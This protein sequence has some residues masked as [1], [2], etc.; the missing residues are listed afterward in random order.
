[1]FQ[2]NYRIV[3]TEYDDF[4][5]QNGFFQISCND[6]TY[7]EIYDFKLEEIMDKEP[8]YDWFE[9]IIRTVKELEVRNRVFLSDT[10]SY[11]TWIEFRKEHDFV[12]IGLA[13]TETKIGLMD[14]EFN[15]DKIE[16][17]NLEGQTVNFQQLKS[18]IIKKGTEYWDCLIRQNSSNSLP[19][20]LITNLNELKTY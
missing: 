13:T 15:L 6:F 9:R 5:G 17:R 1:M 20:S 14:I 8:L 19:K 18:E 2:L 7:G 3:K 4:I 10:E 11:N 12:T 16:S